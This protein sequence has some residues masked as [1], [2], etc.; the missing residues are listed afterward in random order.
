MLPNRSEVNPHGNQEIQIQKEVQS[1]QEIHGSHSDRKERE[2]THNTTSHL[3]RDRQSRSAYRSVGVAAVGGRPSLPPPSVAFDGGLN[4][5]QPRTIPEFVRPTRP[6]SIREANLSPNCKA[7]QCSNRNV[8]PES[9]KTLCSIKPESFS[10]GENCG[11]SQKK[12]SAIRY[13]NQNWQNKK[14]G[15]Q[16]CVLGKETTPRPVTHSLFC[17]RSL[18]V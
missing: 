15:E 3:D 11:F 16:L 9:N 12:E 5:R 10:S 17:F 6:Y 14:I 7:S 8:L 4:V 2:V 1:T 18:L 13:K